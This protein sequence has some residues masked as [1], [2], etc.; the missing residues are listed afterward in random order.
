MEPISS[1]NVNGAADVMTPDGW[2]PS[3]RDNQ[4]F[5]GI[6]LPDTYPIMDVVFDTENVESVRIR[7]TNG[8]EEILDEPIDVSSSMTPFIVYSP[9]YEN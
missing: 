3:N 1:S 9:Y 6:S 4:P 5:V 7:V 8:N 2:K